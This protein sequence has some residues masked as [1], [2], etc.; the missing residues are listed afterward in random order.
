MV[1]QFVNTAQ[2]SQNILMYTFFKQSLFQA[3]MGSSLFFLG[4]AGLCVPDMYAQETTGEQER[5]H[6]ETIQRQ[7]QE[8]QTKYEEIKGREHNLV[9]ELQKIDQRLKESQQK[10]EQYRQKLVKNEK[11]LKTA[12]TNLNNLQTQYTET[13]AILVK[14]LRAIYKMGELGY[15]APLLAMASQTHVQQQ[16]TYLQR[17]AESDRQL[18]NKARDNMEAILKEKAALEKQKKEILQAQKDIEWQNREILTQKQQKTELLARIQ[19]DKHQFAKVL[20]GLQESAGK[21]DTLLQKLETTLPEKQRKEEYTGPDVTIPSNAQDLVKSYREHF[22]S[23]KGRL[24]WPVQGTIITNFGKIEIG[25][26]YTHS[27]G[28]DIKASNG[29]PF[30]AVFK[31]KVIYAGW[32][33]GYGNLVVVDH[34]GDFY[35]LYAHADEL[36]VKVGDVV[37]TRQILGKVGDTDSI[38][39]SVLHFEVRA[40]GK[41]Q[42]PQLWLAQAG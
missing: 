36:L 26:T 22:R 5:A 25:G 12:E 1:W 40:S 14:R 24:L 17:I 37:E 31:G 8:N 33:D 18:L 38:K 20:E 32:F 13:N 29:T 10:L 21:L 15:L 3:I 7:L 30:H 41:P 19:N 34:G 35:T 27:K 9:G 42:N 28:V 39:G 4:L 23:N 11:G 2:I 6:L 16:I